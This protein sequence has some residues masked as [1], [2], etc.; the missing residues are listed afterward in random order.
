M[1]GEKVLVTMPHGKRSFW[2]LNIDS[3]LILNSTL[4]KSV[5]EE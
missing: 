5:L 1:L 3:N 2:A 4:H